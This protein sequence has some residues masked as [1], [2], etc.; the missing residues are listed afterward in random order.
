VTFPLTRSC[1]ILAV[2]ALAAPVRAED[3]GA[4]LKRAAQAMGVDRVKTIRYAGRGSAA[5]FGQ[6]FRPG[7]AW[8]RPHQPAWVREVPRWHIRRGAREEPPPAAVP[9]AHS[10]GG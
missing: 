7:M 6:A 2:A 1:L 9:A 3:A 8:P 10:P 5:S 4:V